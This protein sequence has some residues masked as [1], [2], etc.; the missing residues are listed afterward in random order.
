MKSICAKPD[1]SVAAL[2][3][4]TLLGLPDELFPGGAT[5]GWWLKAARPRSEGNDLA[6]ASASPFVILVTHTKQKGPLLSQ[7]ALLIWLGD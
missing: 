1:N 6:G 5:A 3:S 2:R 7:R 4:R